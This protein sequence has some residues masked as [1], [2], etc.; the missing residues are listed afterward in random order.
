MSLGG[1][2]PSEVWGISG[3]CTGAPGGV[4]EVGVLFV[5]LGLVEFWRRPVS[6]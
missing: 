2:I 5:V 1:V 4:E 3:R 6:G